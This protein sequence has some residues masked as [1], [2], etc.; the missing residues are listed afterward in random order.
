MIMHGSAVAR[1][2]LIDDMVAVTGPQLPML[3][4]RVF[5]CSHGVLQVRARWQQTAASG[6]AIPD[7]HGQLRAEVQESTFA[8]VMI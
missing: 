5:V 4:S 2:I 8:V 3:I 7:F 6:E 1:P